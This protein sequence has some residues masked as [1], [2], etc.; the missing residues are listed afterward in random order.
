LASSIFK[1]LVFA[2]LILRNSVLADLIFRN[3]WLSLCVVVKLVLSSCSECHR[4]A[5]LGCRQAQLDVLG[6][7]GPLLPASLQ[8]RQSPGASHPARCAFC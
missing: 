1:K 5:D 7:P 4:H 6:H 8:W 3:V 2:D